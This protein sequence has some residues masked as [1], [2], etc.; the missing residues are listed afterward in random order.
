MNGCVYLSLYVLGK[1]LNQ[2]KFR[3]PTSIFVVVFLKV[4]KDAV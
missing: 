3:Y 4:G 2:F 1:I